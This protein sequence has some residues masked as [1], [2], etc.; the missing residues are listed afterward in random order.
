M[1]VRRTRQTLAAFLLVLAGALLLFEFR[2]WRD[3]KTEPAASVVPA[4][5]CF[6]AQATRA[7]ARGSI[8]H[9]DDIVLR[10]VTQAPSSGI[11]T[12]V[13]DAM[14]R[15]AT[16]NIQTSEPISETNTTVSSK[17]L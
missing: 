12:N 8:L 11:L 10:E 14:E 2:N 1:S 13:A 7:L 5:H 9:R 6:V 3:A 4:Q 16:R 17:G 15:V